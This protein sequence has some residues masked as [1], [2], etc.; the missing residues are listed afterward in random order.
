MIF[1]H[2]NHV[3]LNM[4]HSNQYWTAHTHKLNVS[5]FHFL[6]NQENHFYTHVYVS[7]KSRRSI[8]QRSLETFPLKWN[9]VCTEC[10]MLTMSLYWCIQIFLDYPVIKLYLSSYMNNNFLWCFLRVVSHTPE[11]HSFQ[12]FHCSKNNNQNISIWDNNLCANVVRAYEKATDNKSYSQDF[13]LLMTLISKL[14]SLGNIGL[15]FS[16]SQLIH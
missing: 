16:V 11:Q 13:L 7:S 6:R 14:Q 12:S 10:V 1:A 9:R 3:F 5:C 8:S 2:C 4:F 15:S